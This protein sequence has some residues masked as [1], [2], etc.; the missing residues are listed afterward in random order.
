MAMPMSQMVEL[1]KPESMPTSPLP[2]TTG[3]SPNRPEMVSATRQTAPIGITLAMMATIV[4]TNRASMCQARG[5]R[6]PGVG[7]RN[8]PGPI[9]TGMSARFQSKNIL[10]R[11]GARGG[12]F[13]GFS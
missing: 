9:I 13:V 5:S 2:G 6:P 10:T 11:T 8:I 3:V 1:A 4:A 12:A 7:M